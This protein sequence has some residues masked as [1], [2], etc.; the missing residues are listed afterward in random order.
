M[1]EVGLLLSHRAMK[2][3]DNLQSYSK[4][5][6][7]ATYCGNPATTVIV[8]YSPT[9]VWTESDLE[10]F[11]DQLR[12][13]IQDTPR[14]NF[15]VVLGDVNA[16]LGPNDVTFPFHSSTNRNCVFLREL[17]KEYNLLVTN[18]QFEKKLGKRWTF[19]DWRPRRNASWII[20]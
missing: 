18:T 12:S 17:V 7:S 13:A 6:L 9:N 4:R 8:A 10:L 1:G 20:S 3:L 16:R 5:V 19:C 2:A 15:L 11:Y 14:H